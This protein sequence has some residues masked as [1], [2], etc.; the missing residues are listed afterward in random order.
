[1]SFM[2]I[3]IGHCL[4]TGFVPFGTRVGRVGACSQEKRRR[5]HLERTRLYAMALDVRRAS[6]CNQY[7]LAGLVC[8]SLDV[9]LVSNR[10]KLACR[11]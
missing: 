7:V 2:R 8:S 5:G 11:I 4:A 6:G 3:D 9:F 10:C 1:M